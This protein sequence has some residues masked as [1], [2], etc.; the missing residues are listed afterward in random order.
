[1]NP[2]LKLWLQEHMGVAED[3]SADE[4]SNALGK[5][6][7]TGKLTGEKYADLLRDPKAEQAS[8]IKSLL[9]DLA[10]GIKS[11]PE[12]LAGLMT[13]TTPEPVAEPKAAPVAVA[14]PVVEPKAAPTAPKKRSLFADMF[15]KMGTDG[16]AMDVSTF[17]AHKQYATT[18]SA[19]RFATT[20][21]H[22]RPHP[23]GGQQVRDGDRSL[24]DQ[25]E[26]D[27]AACG[28]WAKFL[29]HSQKV[30]GIP[31]SMR[32]TDHDWQ[33]LD[34]MSN[35]MKWSGCLRGDGT[36]TEGVIGV[37]GRLLSTNEKAALLD[38]ATSDGLE[39]APIV[40]DDAII[41]V[42]YLYGEFFPYVT[43]VPITRGRRIEGGA[44]GQVTG[45]SGG[46]DATDIP[47]FDSTSQVSAFDTTIFGW[48]GAIEIGLD[49]LS[50]SPINVGAIITQMYGEALMA[51]LDEQIVMGDGSTE[52]EGIVEKSGTTSVSHGSIAPT[53]SAYVNMVAGIA[54]NEKATVPA[55]RIMFGGNETSY[56][57]ARQ[58]ATGVTGDTRLVFGD[59]IES[60]SVLGHRY[61]INN[62]MPNTKLFFACMP[63]YRMYR[64]LGLSMRAST[65]GKTL[66]RLNQM[67]LTA[68]A[69]FGGQL[70]RGACAVYVST[71][72]A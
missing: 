37:R 67:L 13:K 17:D 57:R 72:Q 12:Q 10:A 63:R 48:N 59:D 43:V 60:Y 21:K 14:E 62:T 35:D 68:R 65:E 34:Y 19:L 33:M 11:L 50:D 22:S 31:A 58:I 71:A 26:L 61:G 30:S 47:L 39:I 36:E 70:E 27:K 18:K 20:D 38:D 8:E 64:R 49:F 3:A 51:W 9:T 23:M 40:F 41:T 32:M 29:L 53:L 44:I 66:I 6:L 46:A 28:V 1:M 56:Y 45:S 25:S 52:P 2:K 54:K 69:R 5:A 15:A 55:E 42:P 7:A 24:D 16:A 4:F